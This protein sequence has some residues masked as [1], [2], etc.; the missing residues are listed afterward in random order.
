MGNPEWVVPYPEFSLAYGSYEEQ[1]QRVSVNL[2]RLEPN[3]TERTPIIGGLSLENVATNFFR[4]ATAITDDLGD[5][6][7]ITEVKRLIY[8]LPLLRRALDK[9]GYKEPSAKSWLEHSF[10][11][12]KE[13]DR[14]LSTMALISTLGAIE[15]NAI[16]ARIGYHRPGLIIG[17]AIDKRTRGNL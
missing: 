5:P 7:Q 11:D 16:K 14:T 1:V 17:E 6:W 13:Q 2:Q 9:F 4:L 3:L 15:P 8:D 12:R 10:I